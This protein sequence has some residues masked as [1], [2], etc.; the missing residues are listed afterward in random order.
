M[1]WKLRIALKEELGKLQQIFEENY[2][3]NGGLLV[4]R[5]FC[6][7]E[8]NLEDILVY[9]VDGNIVGYVNKSHILKRVPTKW[10]EN[11]K[12]DSF[13]FINQIAVKTSEQRKGHGSKI[14]TLILGTSPVVYAYVKDGNKLSADF[15]IKFGFDVVGVW[16]K[17]HF[18]GVDNYKAYLYRYES[19]G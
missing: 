10:Y 9:Q 3:G 17:D 7:K 8:E 1:A 5:D 18:Q 19:K 16:E 14:Y 13:T 12:D 6:P 15:H 2:V 11:F 4:S